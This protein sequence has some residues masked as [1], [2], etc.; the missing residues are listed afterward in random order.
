MKTMKTLER[1]NSRNQER[2]M[3]A[4]AMIAMTTLL[5]LLL[6]V[7]ALATTS[8]GTDFEKAIANATDELRVKSALLEKIGWDMLNV[9]V[10]ADSGH[11]TLMGITADKTHQEMAK[12]VAL[13]LEG[14]KHVTNKLDVKASESNSTTAVVGKAVTNSELEVKDAILESRVKTALISELGMNAFDIEVE[15]ADGTVSLRGALSDE[16]YGDLA[17][18]TAE[19]C[20]GVDSVVDLLTIEK[21]S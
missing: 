19:N 16:K 9:D 17:L 13:S 3:I 21:S 2:S 10:E 4:P 7:P 20:K 11:I 18:K 12:E 15:A 8:T 6:A 1:T 5:L 14:V